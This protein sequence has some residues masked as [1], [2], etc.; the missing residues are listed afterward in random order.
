LFNLKR[1]VKY[2]AHVEVLI[3]EVYIVEE[4][5]TFISYYFGP[6]LRIRINR[7]LRHDD[8]RK[9]SL[10]EN[11]SIFS[12]LGR[13]VLKIAVKGRYMSEIEFR[14]VHNHGIFNCNELRP[15]IQ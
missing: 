7:V 13:S 4:I 5:S 8:G 15:F 9:V 14:Q 6:Q 2:K 3:C 12:H 1:K 10:C 11:L